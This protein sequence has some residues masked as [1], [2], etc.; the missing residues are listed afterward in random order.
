[1]SLESGQQ[2]DTGKFSGV[3]GT[4]CNDWVLLGDQPVVAGFVFGE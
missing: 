2:L 1:M 3:V 4:E